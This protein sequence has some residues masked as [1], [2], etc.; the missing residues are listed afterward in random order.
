MIFWRS[1]IYF[2]NGDSLF[3]IRVTVRSN[4]SVRGNGYYEF[5]VCNTFCRPKDCILVMRWVLRG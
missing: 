5:N 1:L 2:I 3:R 4:E